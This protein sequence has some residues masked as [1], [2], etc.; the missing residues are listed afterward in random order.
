VGGKQ[1][2]DSKSR[3]GLDCVADEVLPACKGLLKEA[4]ALDHLVAGIDVERGAVTLGESFKR[5]FAAGE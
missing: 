3:V 4:E 2:E 1:L 5:D